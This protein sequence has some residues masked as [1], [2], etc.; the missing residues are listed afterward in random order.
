MDEYRIVAERIANDL[1]SYCENGGD[2]NNLDARKFMS[3]INGKDMKCDDILVEH[4]NLDEDYIFLKNNLSPLYFNVINKI[5]GIREKDFN[6]LNM[7]DK[8]AF[9]NEG[10]RLYELSK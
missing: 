9:I 6:K 4:T 8:K 7:N 1:K 10:Y 2:I 5:C 3:F